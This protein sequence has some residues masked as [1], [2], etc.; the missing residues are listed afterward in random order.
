MAAADIR[1]E[2]HASQ[3]ESP[4]L[5]CFKISLLLNALTLSSSFHLNF[6]LHNL[7]LKGP[8]IIY[9]Q[10]GGGGLEEI[11][12]GGSEF[13]LVWRGG[14]SRKIFLFEGGGGYEN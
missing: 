3:T 1:Y 2:T 11:K 10:G 13:F 8:V 5:T 14:G 7:I 9:A 6:T 4:Q 12:G